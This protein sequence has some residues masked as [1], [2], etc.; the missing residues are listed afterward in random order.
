MRTEQEIKDQLEIA[1]NNM[2][3]AQDNEIIGLRGWARALSWALTDAKDDKKD[4][5][6]E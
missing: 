5:F 2:L 6:T 3:Y 1:K 4:G